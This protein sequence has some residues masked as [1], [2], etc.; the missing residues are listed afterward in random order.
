MFAIDTMGGPPG[1]LRRT[2]VWMILT[3]LA[4]PVLEQRPDFRQFPESP[5]AG[6]NQARGPNCVQ[7]DSRLLSM[8]ECLHGPNGETRRG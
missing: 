3:P 2:L 6:R 8:M 1:G 5:F 4:I 7:Q